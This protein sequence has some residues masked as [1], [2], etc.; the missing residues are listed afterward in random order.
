MSAFLLAFDDYLVT[1]KPPAALR[2]ILRCDRD[3]QWIEHGKHLPSTSERLGQLA[4]ST[5]GN[6]I[7]ACCSSYHAPALFGLSKRTERSLLICVAPG[8]LNRTNK[9]PGER[10][11]LGNTTVGTSHFQIA[12]RVPK[13]MPDGELEDI[14]SDS[15]LMN[16]VQ[17]LL[18]GEFS[19]KGYRFYLNDFYHLKHSG[20]HAK[21]IS[22]HE[23]GLPD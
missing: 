8:A 3:F 15:N 5:T 10:R 11:A 21:R 19:C 7:Y 23:I 12:F 1:F 13:K 18:S 20:Y 2:K 16:T 9:F 6:I 22:P 17:Y 4:F 14:L